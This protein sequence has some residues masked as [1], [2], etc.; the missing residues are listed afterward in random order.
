MK[1][2]TLRGSSYR[3]KEENMISDRMGIL[4]RWVEYFDELRN[5]QKIY[6]LEAPPAED[7]GQ[8][9]PPPSIGETVRAIHRLKNHKSPGADGI[10]AELVQHVGDQLHQALHQPM[11]MVWDIESV[12]GGWQ[13]GIICLIHKKGDITQCN[14]YRGITMLSTIYKIFSAIL[15]DRI[16]PYGPY[17]R[18]F[19]P[20][21]S[22]TDQISSLRQAMEK[23]LEYGHQ[24]H[25]FFIGFKTTY[26]GIII[27]IVDATIQLD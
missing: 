27:T 8:I 6:E 4:E 25:H 10:T 26:G 5:N 18:G 2:Y 7:D 24:L 20:G 1:P 23:L 22:A 19:T 21:K 17:Q 13:R 12:P 11:L 9:L 14:N 3:D 16:A 15:L